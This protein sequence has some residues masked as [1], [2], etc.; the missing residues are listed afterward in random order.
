MESQ[1]FLI[2]DYIKNNTKIN[3]EI[4]KVPIVQVDKIVHVLMY[5]GF[6]FSML[7]PYASQYL[8]K[9]KRL[10]SLSKVV[11]LGVTYG[12][13]MEILQATLF[14]NRSGNWYD[15]WANLIGVITGVLFFLFVIRGEK[16]NSAI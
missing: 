14:I 16:L 11:L 2:N 10:T 7:I 6:T 3:S 15:F 13:L 4:P 1:N 12:G 9:K 5:A 8:E